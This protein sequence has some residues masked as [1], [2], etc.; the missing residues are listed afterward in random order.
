[1][2]TL[3]E[4]T[5]KVTNDAVGT[6]SHEVH[7]LSAGGLKPLATLS[8]QLGLTPHFPG[9]AALHGADPVIRSPHPRRGIRNGSVSDRYRGRRNLAYA[10]WPAD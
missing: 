7:S 4:M 8:D 3:K 9:D 6:G 2:T 10:H 5:S 1:M